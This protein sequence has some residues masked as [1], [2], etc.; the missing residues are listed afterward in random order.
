M[1]IP[2]DVIAIIPRNI[3]KKYRVIPLFKSDGKIAVAHRRPVRPEH[4]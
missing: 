1:K 2:D 4:D 3:A